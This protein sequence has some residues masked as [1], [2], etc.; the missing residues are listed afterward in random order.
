LLELV[1]YP[2]LEELDNV[3]LEEL[4]IELLELEVLLEVELEVD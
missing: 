1:L 4:S 3:E 2:S